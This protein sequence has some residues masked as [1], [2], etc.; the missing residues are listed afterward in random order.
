MI[1]NYYANDE[2]FTKEMVKDGNKTAD[3][4]QMID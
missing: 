4:N 2:F 3:G 1:V